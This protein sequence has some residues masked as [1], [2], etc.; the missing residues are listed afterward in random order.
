MVILLLVLL[1][2]ALLTHTHHTHKFDPSKFY[3][4]RMGYFPNKKYI[5]LH[6]APHWTKIAAGA[7]WW[8]FSGLQG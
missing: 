1:E 4:L 8:G 6:F 2:A 5:V 3:L 7:P